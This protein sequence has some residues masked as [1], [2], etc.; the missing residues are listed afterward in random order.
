MEGIAGKV[1]GFYQWRAMVIAS[2][3]H[4][5]NTLNDCGRLAQNDPPSVID[6]I[7]ITSCRTNARATFGAD[8]VALGNLFVEMGL[9]SVELSLWFVTEMINCFGG[10]A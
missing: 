2:V 1:D 10:S 9:G 3:E 8:M 6:Q 7:R 5:E 4:M